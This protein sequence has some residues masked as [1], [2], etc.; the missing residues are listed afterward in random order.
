MYKKPIII[1]CQP[2]DDFFLWQNHL[3]IE[4]CINAGFEEDRI[5]ILLYTPPNRQYNSNWDKLKK[6]YPKLNIFKY[7]DKGIGVSRFLGVYIPLLRP[8]ILWQ[9]F[10]KFPELSKETILYT[11]SDILWT[12]N[13][14]IFKLFDDNVCYLS[15]AHGYMNNDYF[16]SKYDHI[17]ESKKIKLK[18]RDFLSEICNLSGITKDI[19]VQNNKNIGGVQYI[20]KNID[21]EFWK[22]VEL[23][24][25]HIRIHLMNVNKEFYENENRGIQSWCSD[26]WAVV[27]NLWYRKYEV[28][29]VPEMDFA[30]S[31]DPI[32]KLDK[33]GIFH[34]AGIGSK[35][36]GDIPVFYK[37]DYHLGKNPF[38][39][40]HLEE[41]YNNEKS[42]TLCNHY[43][44]SE[45]ISL[46][47]KYNL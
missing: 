22:K 5:H 10:E 46:K 45:M 17:L 2:D 6:Y 44:V 34:N 15:D 41:V 14:D 24:C 4:S 29:I 19:V 40:P 37:G 21:S 3:Y 12:K 16:E 1:T 32:S 30:W 23:D 9:H 27:F 7:G 20:L 28:K 38:S 31:T 39:D 8:H 25:L 18:E 47:N 11:D 35:L 42:K 43:Y 33:V 36:L 26:L 13:L